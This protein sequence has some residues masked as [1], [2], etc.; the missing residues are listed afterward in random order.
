MEDQFQQINHTL[1]TVYS[2]S[3]RL[4]MD[5]GLVRV[6]PF[7]QSY[8]RYEFPPA[9][10]GEAVGWTNVFRFA[11]LEQ[12]PGI[13]VDMDTVFL[14]SF[15]P[16]WEVYDQG[17][18][19]ASRWAN[20]EYVSTSVLGIPPQ[21]RTLASLPFRTHSFHPEPFSNVCCEEAECKKELVLF[22]PEF[23]DPLSLSEEGAAIGAADESS[24]CGLSKYEDFFSASASSHVNVTC[25]KSSSFAAHWHGQWDASHCTPSSPIRL[26]RDSFAEVVNARFG[27]TIDL[28]EE[29]RREGVTKIFAF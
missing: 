4:F 2:G 10:V 8:S 18:P 17:T 21:A 6:H 3:L 12:F 20:R 11:I 5:A 26:L 25:L 24:W 19:F 28:C 15:T 7:R 9:D 14:R 16:I 23:F 1:S 29:E 13:Y 22:P 27:Y